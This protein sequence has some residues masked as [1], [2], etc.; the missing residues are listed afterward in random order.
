MA[1]LDDD[2]APV[3]G[4]IR[5]PKS[6]FRDDMDHLRD[7]VVDS[8]LDRRLVQLLALHPHL[9]IRFRNPDLQCLDLRTKKALL[10]D[11]NDVLGI[12]LLRSSSR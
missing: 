6:R 2:Y 4:G 10:A 11:I 1:K 3:A 12:R 8:D 5:L 9:R 7:L